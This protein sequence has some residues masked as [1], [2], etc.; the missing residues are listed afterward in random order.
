[1]SI[2]LSLHIQALVG[3]HRQLYLHPQLQTVLSTA[4]DS[5]IHIHCHRQFYTYP[6]QRLWPNLLALF[7]GFFTPHNLRSLLGLF[8]RPSHKLA[9][10]GTLS[11]TG[12]NLLSSGSL[13]PQTHPPW[14]RINVSDC[15]L[16]VF[17]WKWLIWAS[18]L[19][20]VERLKWLWS[21]N[22]QCISRTVLRQVSIPGQVRR[23]FMFPSASLPLEITWVT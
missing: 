21:P 1:M 3:G 12:S 6:Q 5:S 14:S 15:R 17:E 23:E 16:L 20:C 8:T 18:L 13:S 11:G 19:Q 22:R 7:V 2:T 9:P 10:W 4:T